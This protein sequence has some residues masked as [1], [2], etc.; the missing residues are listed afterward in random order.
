MG[1]K[2]MDKVWDNSK[3]T[4]TDRLVLLA[5][6]KTYNK[7][8]GS[9][10]S[11]DELADKCGMDKRSVRRSINRLK[12]LGEL[13]WIV[14]SAKSGKS[15]TYFI[16]FIER[17]EMSGEGMTEMSAIVTDLSAEKTDLSAENDRNVRPLN[18]Q[19]NKLNKLD[20]FFDEFWAVY[21][22]K[23]S[24]GRAVKAFEVALSKTDVVTLL[25]ASR[26]FRDVVV[27]RDLRFVKL[28]HNWL[29]DECWLDSVGVADES[30]MDRA[31]DD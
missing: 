9:W 12:A 8:R 20:S 17:P 11:Q 1:Y 3:S 2:E 15:N 19:L 13:A 24:R 14:G 10:P 27:G 28:A 30:W 25:A 21:P 7:G 23:E 18:N 26:T 4:K 16:S 5:I 22:R 29:A 6:A 31:I